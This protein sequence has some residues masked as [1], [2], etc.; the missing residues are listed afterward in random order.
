VAENGS[1]ER[2]RRMADVKL[3]C[4]ERENAADE[5]LVHCRRPHAANLTLHLEV[6]TR[7]SGRPADCACTVLSVIMFSEVNAP[8]ELWVGFGDQFWLNEK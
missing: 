8:V 6:A 2:R 3:E 7:V 5:R 4:V 1:L